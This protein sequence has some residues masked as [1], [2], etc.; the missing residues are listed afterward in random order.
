MTLR[1]V[2]CIAAIALPIAGTPAIAQFQAAP[3]SEAAPQQQPPPCLKKFIALRDETAKKAEAIQTAGNRK[4]KPSA[5]D[6]CKLFNSFIAAEDKLI[7]YATEN[8]VWCGIPD[9]VVQ[10]MKEAHVKSSAVRTKVCR[11]AA[12]GPPQP[13]GPSLSEALGANVPTTDNVK[14]GLGTF[15]TLIGSPL[16][17][18]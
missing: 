12:A 8:S 16:G 7:K 13:R 11:V 4:Q 14:T 9:E 15:D 1:R 17:D 3:M 6:A 10:Q 2:I 18:R 5:Q